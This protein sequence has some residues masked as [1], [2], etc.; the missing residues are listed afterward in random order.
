LKVRVSGGFNGFR[1]GE[2]NTAFFVDSNLAL[3]GKTDNHNGE[4]DD[5]Y[6]HGQGRWEEGGGLFEC[7]AADDIGAECSK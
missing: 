7:A 2:G 5:D 4:I 6:L 3:L 1:G